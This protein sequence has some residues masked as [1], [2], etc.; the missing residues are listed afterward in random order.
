MLALAATFGTDVLR[1]VDAIRDQQND[2]ALF[3]FPN[4]AGEWLGLGGITDG[5]R[6]VALIALLATLALTLTLT[7]RRRL[8]WYEAA[9]WATAVLLVT[10][11]WLLPWYL[12]WL[13]P[14]AALSADRRLRVATLAIG[15]FLVY[16]RVDLWFGL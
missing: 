9:G 8:P 13:L 5:I 12:V 4:K 16:T 7:W 15:A 1:L 14:L 3:S 11:A 2:V 10:S 6:A